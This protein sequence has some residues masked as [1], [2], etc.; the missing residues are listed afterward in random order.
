MKGIILSAELK[1]QTEEQNN[2]RHALMV[3][4]LN[5]LG[6]HFTQATGVFEGVKE[7][8]LVV[9]SEY[10]PQIER[11]ADFFEQAS[12][13]LFDSETRQAQV[14]PIRAKHGSIDLKITYFGQSNV[15]FIGD[16]TVI[17]SSIGDI[18]LKCERE[19]L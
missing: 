2:D 8:S 18:G 1:N 19:V 17:H 9:D 13:L 5:N 7:R 11:L 16:H 6:I 3:K 10:L 15:A 12:I 14:F 4:M